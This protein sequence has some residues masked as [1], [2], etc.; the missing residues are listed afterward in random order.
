MNE[1]IRDVWN[2]VEILINLIAF[3]KSYNFFYSKQQTIVI[4]IYL[5][6]SIIKNIR[7]HLI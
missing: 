2:N 6:L 3:T 7:M 4:M 1:W 5:M